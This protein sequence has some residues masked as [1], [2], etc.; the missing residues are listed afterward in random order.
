MLRDLPCNTIL[1]SHVADVQDS[2]GKIQYYPM[3]AGKLRKQIPGF[4]DF[5]GYMKA[6]VGDDGRS[7]TEYA[8]RQDGSCS[9]KATQ[10]WV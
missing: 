7:N 3:L 5:V 8:I 1:T 10:L 2:L 4:L 6:E 9:S